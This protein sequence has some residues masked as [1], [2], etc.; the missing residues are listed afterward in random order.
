MYCNIIKQYVQQQFC[1]KMLLS[2][3]CYLCTYFQCM[4]GIQCRED[5]QLGK[6]LASA[7]PECC[8]LEVI[9]CPG[10]TW[11]NLG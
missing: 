10:I 4:K 7:I 9:G 5:F 1:K 11:S 6:S 3:I 2:R 8:A